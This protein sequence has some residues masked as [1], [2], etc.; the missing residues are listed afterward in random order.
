MVEALPDAREH[1]ERDPRH[2]LDDTAERAVRQHEDADGVVP[3][4]RVQRAVGK[5]QEARGC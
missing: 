3:S 4:G 5:T 1:F 2:R